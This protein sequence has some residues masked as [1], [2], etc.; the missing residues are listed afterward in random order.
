MELG[1]QRGREEKLD[2]GSFYEKW[3]FEPTHPK[4]KRMFLKS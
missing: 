1:V 3:G 2:I 4:S